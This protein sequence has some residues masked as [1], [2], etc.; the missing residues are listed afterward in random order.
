MLIFSS[1]DCTG[2]IIPNSPPSI[3]SVLETS[4]D[5]DVWSCSKC[6]TKMSSYDVM[7]LLGKIGDRLSKFDKKN[8]ALCKKFIQDFENILHPN[9]YYLTDV[10]LSLV[11]SF[12]QENGLTLL[13]DDDLQLKLKYCRELYNLTSVL[14]PAENRLRGVLL[15]ELH[16]AIAENGRRKSNRGEMDPAELKSNLLVRFR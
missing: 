5:E 6:D 10:K 2:Y 15:Y 12:G 1:S 14:V 11:Q 9:H 13:K 3:E 16:A 8:E 4:K 7:S